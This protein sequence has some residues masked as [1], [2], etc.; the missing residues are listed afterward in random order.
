MS[1]SCSW[2]GKDR[3][4][5]FR[6]QMKH[7]VQVKLCYP[8][9]MRAVPKCLRGAS[10]RGAIQMNIYLYLYSALSISLVCVDIARLMLFVIRS[11]DVD[12]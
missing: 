3:Y 9:T 2:E 5:S 7:G 10:C 11:A 12:S 4:G 8:L 6:L 1:T